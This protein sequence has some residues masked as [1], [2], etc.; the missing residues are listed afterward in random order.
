MEVEPKNFR[1]S[2][3]DTLFNPANKSDNHN[4]TFVENNNKETKEFDLKSKKG[5]NSDFENQSS[6]Y[7]KFSYYT[8]QQNQKN[9]SLKDKFILSDM[10]K[11]YKF[12]IFPYILIVHILIVSLS[13]LIVSIYFSFLNNII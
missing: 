2:R 4:F 6:E 11:Y 12:G 3:M 10:A 5:I 7:D 13:T 9:I 1:K 8:I